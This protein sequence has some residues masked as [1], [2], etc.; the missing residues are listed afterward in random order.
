MKL[1]RLCKVGIPILAPSEEFQLFR[2]S[3][4]VARFGVFSTSIC[5]KSTILPIFT[6][7]LHTSVL[8]CIQRGFK[9]SN[10]GTYQLVCD[11]A[12]Y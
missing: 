12:T 5:E 3:D 10:I 2:F 8:P 9:V 4:L 11:K 6:G 1:P 7:N